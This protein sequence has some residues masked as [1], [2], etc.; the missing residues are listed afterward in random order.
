MYT[1]SQSHTT[2]LLHLCDMQLEEYVLWRLRDVPG[3]RTLS[4]FRQQP[5]TAS[6]ATEKPSHISAALPPSPYVK[7]AAAAAA[8]SQGQAS[9]A[10]PSKSCEKHGAQAAVPDKHQAS[11][12]LPGQAADAEF[13]NPMQIAQGASRSELSTSNAGPAKALNFDLAATAE[14]RASSPSTAEPNL[15]SDHHALGAHR[16]AS[17][18]P[19]RLTSGLPGTS[20]LNFHD[21]ADVNADAAGNDESASYDDTE[22]ALYQHGDAAMLSE[23]GAVPVVETERAEAPA[24]PRASADYRLAQERAAA[25]RAACD[26]LRGP[27][28][29]SRDDPHF[30]DSYYKSSRLSFIGRWKARIEALTATTAAHAPLP[31]TAHQPSALASALRGN[32]GIPACTWQQNFGCQ[33][34]AAQPLQLYLSSSTCVANS[35]L[36]TAVHVNAVIMFWFWC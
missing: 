3:Q 34:E 8:S 20:H 26:L 23:A 29:S 1:S 5:G 6:H 28:K 22:D 36:Y 16:A 9:E 4:A 12:M 18:P 32:Q 30:M 10:T 2:N 13:M 7:F 27:P 11:D 21:D 24:D 14:A 19:P 35:Q 15:L 33:L 17:V 25:A 31:Q